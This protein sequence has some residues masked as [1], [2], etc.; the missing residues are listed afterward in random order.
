M[1]HLAALLVLLT[2]LLGC[3]SPPAA[4]IEPDPF[5]VA[6]MDFSLDVVIMAGEAA[7]GRVEAHVR[8]S[9]YVLFP[10][11]SLHYG[12]ADLR[13]RDGGAEGMP[14]F[15]RRLDRRQ[16]AA[17]WSEA[18]QI[19]FADPGNGTEPSNFSLIEPEG[20]E[21]VHL[22]RFTGGGDG[23][24]FVRRSSVEAP[25]AA[26]AQLVRTLARLA[27]A[28]EA[29]EGETISPPRRYD[30]GPDPYAAYRR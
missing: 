12:T 21:I 16:V 11:G 30:F 5:A 17:V 8:A 29:F 26:A 9:H 6:P 7:A 23:W 15:V 28:T 24:E 1:R 2:M 3:E 22:L 4:E 18:Q 14:P 27:W 20:D 10:D 25:D 19:G 13:S